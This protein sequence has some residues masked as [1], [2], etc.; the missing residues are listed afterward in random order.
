[1]GMGTGMGIEMGMA[2]GSK[3]ENDVRG[4]RIDRRL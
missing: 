3:E 1:M 4:E 2:V